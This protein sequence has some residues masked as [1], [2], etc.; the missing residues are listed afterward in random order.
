MTE[1][2]QEKYT[3]EEL[4]KLREAHFAPSLS[5]SYKSTNPLYIVKGEKQY[6]IDEK[7]TKYL[8]CRNNV[9]HV[10][11]SHPEITK[12]VNEQLKV[13]NTNTRYLHH[14]VL[15]YAKQLTSKFSKNL[16]YVIFVNSGIYKLN[17]S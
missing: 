11:H 10:G 2:L 6:L 12:V 4:L 13:L 5:V 8:D 15:E 7:G 16:N 1:L 9:S 14:N 17:V 3:K